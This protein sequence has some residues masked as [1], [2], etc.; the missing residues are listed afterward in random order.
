MIIL[1]VYAFKCIIIS[2][3]DLEMQEVACQIVFPIANPPFGCYT[4]EI[5]IEVY[6]HAFLGGMGM[7]FK[8]K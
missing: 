2:I 8:C 4:H 3:F 5:H 6:G 7:E 1:N